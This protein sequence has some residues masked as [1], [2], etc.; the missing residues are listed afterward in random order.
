MLRDNL[1]GISKPSI[2]RLARR[3]GVKRI[4]GE[5][6][7][8]WIWRFPR[9]AYPTLNIPF[10]L[11]RVDLRRRQKQLEQDRHLSEMIVSKF[12]VHRD[13]WRP[14]SLPQNERLEPLPLL[15]V[16]VPLRQMRVSPPT[17]E[18]LIKDA[19]VFAEHVRQTLT[20]KHTL[21]LKYSP[22]ITHSP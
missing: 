18:N 8:D 16:S 2:R 5:H 14:Q 12:F 20:H 1:Q 21:A 13:P 22:I 15:P 19:V 7:R 11:I 10:S 17:V 3:G 6:S 9:Y 4:S